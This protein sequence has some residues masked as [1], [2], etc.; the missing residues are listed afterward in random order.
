ML[1]YNSQVYMIYLFS[2]TN[3]LNFNI[4]LSF[5]IK[6]VLELRKENCYIGGMKF[7]DLKDFK[8]HLK[9]SIP[10][11]LGPVFQLIIPNDDERALVADQLV[12]L[13]LKLNPNL[14][15][16]K[17][18]DPDLAQNELDCYSILGDYPLIYLDK[19]K[20]TFTIEVPDGAYLI[21]GMPKSVAKLPEG[22]T[23]DLSKEK[24]WDKDT[25]IKEQVL[26]KAIKSKKQ[27]EHGALE[28]MF[29]AIGPDLALLNRE[30]EKLICYVGEKN[31]IDLAAAQTL[32]TPSKEQSTWQIAEQLVWEKRLPK[33]IASSDFP[34]LVGSIRY[35]LEVGLALHAFSP[36]EFQERYP[37][38]RPRTLDKYRG[39]RLPASYF[40][41]GLQALYKAEWLFKDG[42]SDGGLCLDLFTGHLCSI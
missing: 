38:L 37:K 32:V 5:F 1:L 33:R 16:V 20:K 26:A 6:M 12:S 22:I 18:E 15:L 4:N 13:I 17:T 35:Q 7:S 3:I 39:Y 41:K 8:S 25:R 19:I 24:P 21:L 14:R 34:I 11:G 2:E 40:K 42:V 10:Q 27:L 28:Y 30:L 9:A 29:S 36:E 23:L 31:T